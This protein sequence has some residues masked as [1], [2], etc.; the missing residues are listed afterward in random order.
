MS[1]LSRGDSPYFFKFQY[2]SWV[3]H[4]CLA[5]SLTEGGRGGWSG[6]EHRT[7]HNITATCV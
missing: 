3:F 2:N 6:S 1:E 5:L 7:M 4:G